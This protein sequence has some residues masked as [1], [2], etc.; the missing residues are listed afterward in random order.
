MNALKRAIRPGPTHRPRLQHVYE[1]R[2]AHDL[3]YLTY[4]LPAGHA[5][6]GSTPLLPSSGRA[7]TEYPDPISL[8]PIWDPTSPYSINRPR[9]PPRGRNKGVIPRRPADSH[10]DNLVR[11]EKLV[12]DSFVPEGIH[13]RK[14]LIGAI[15]LL[16]L[17]TGEP[18]RTSL[19]RSV[20]DTIPVDRGIRL[21]HTGDAAVRYRVRRG[22]PC[23]AVVTLKG[24][25][26]YSLIDQLTTFVLPR[27]KD[28][29]GFKLPEPDAS[30]RT[31]SMQGGTVSIGLARDAM[32]LWPG[33]EE[34]MENW[35]R[36][37]GMNIHFVTNARGRGAQEKASV[38]SSPLLAPSSPFCSRA[39]VSGFQIPFARPVDLE[40]KRF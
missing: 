15:M 11:L 30:R 4:S 21:V 6:D 20:L 10:P 38:P 23:G 1:S 18:D 19:P 39:L 14:E 40:P 32:K 26:M 37:Y 12:I 3:L 29:A 5:S 25:M 8:L 17:I 27:A 36:S 7:L 34:S 28:F 24:P 22:Q 2:L 35:P 16:S 31:P 9:R 13:E 33:V